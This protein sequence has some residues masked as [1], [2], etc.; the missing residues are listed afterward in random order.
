MGVVVA[1]AEFLGSVLL[2]VWLGRDPFSTPSFKGSRVQRFEQGMSFYQERMGLHDD[3][4]YR[5]GTHPDHPEYCAWVVR[6]PGFFSKEV[7][8]NPGGGKGCLDLKPER[9]A[10]HESCHLRLAHTEPQFDSV[11]DKTKEEEVESCMKFYG[12]KN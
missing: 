5:I 9:I 4:V 6:M 2:M 11:P 7:G 10:L 1:I 3:L 12:R 8:F